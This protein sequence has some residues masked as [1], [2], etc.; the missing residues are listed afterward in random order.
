MKTKITLVALL[1]LISV[2]SFS[3]KTNDNGGGKV[4]L[5]SHTFLI[6]C[7]ANNKYLDLPGYASKAKK[8]NGAN[9]QLWD[10]DDGKDRMVKF[11][12]VGNGYY[13]IQFQHAKVNLDVH[14]C[15]DGKLFCKTYKKSKGANVQ[16]WSAGNSEPQQ[17]KIEQIKFGQFKITNKY[18]GKVLDA[19]AK[20]INKNG[21][22]V[23]QWPWNGGKNQLWELIEVN[24]R[25]KYHQ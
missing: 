5:N 18:S 16:I 21:C 9:V 15:Y 1:V 19:S 10:L 13:N 22:N 25:I 12:P 20:N 24:T 6:R 7:V 17:W 14:G 3:Q 8:E 4:N 11:V 2:I 23:M